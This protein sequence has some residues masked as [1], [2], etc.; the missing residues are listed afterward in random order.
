[1]GSGIEMARQ[2]AP[3]HA[4]VMDD[5]KDQLILVLVERLGGKVEI[6]V[7]E[8]DGTGGKLLMLAVRDRT[9]IL[10]LRKKS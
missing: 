8:V 4:A 5:F 3:E 2:H 6:P 9:F 7:E 10:E 1:M